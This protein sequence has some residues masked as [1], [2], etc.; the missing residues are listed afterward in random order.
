MTNKDFILKAVE[1]AK[2]ITFDKDKCTSCN[3]CVDACPIDI[4]LP[5]NENE[6]TPTVAY[7]D[8]CWYCGCCVMQCPNNAIVFR[9]PLM[10]QARWVDKN[11]LIKEN[12]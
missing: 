1:S 10:N 4:L 12:K 9:H 6:T 2:P 8:E 7:L 11:S 5:A 3:N